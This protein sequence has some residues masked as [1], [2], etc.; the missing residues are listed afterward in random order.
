MV[1]KAFP[2]SEGYVMTLELIVSLKLPSL[3]SRA[4]TSILDTF[5]KLHTQSDS[6]TKMSGTRM[7][8]DVGITKPSWKLAPS[9][10]LYAS[11]LWRQYCSPQ[12]PPNVRTTFE[13]FPPLSCTPRP[14]LDI[15]TDMGDSSSRKRPFV[16]HSTRPGALSALQA[17]LIRCFLRLG[18]QSSCGTGRGTPLIGLRHGVLFS[19]LVCDMSIIVSLVGAIDE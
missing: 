1:R 15:K 16:R 8:R 6:S 19:W 11:G 17:P 5:L 18:V 4:C 7:S 3:V 9:S 13:S 14:I 10:S 12:S 2:R